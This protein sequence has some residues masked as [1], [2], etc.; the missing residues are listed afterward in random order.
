M[1]EAVPELADGGFWYHVAAVDV[2]DGRSTG[3]DLPVG[4]S[5]TATYL[6]D[7]TVIVRSPVPLVGVDTVSAEVALRLVAA[8]VPE[9]PYGR[10]RGR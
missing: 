6:A 8:G 1:L 4:A 2:R 10:I 3:P 7:D 5:F 9:R